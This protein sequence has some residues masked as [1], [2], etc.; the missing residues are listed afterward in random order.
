M[1]VWLCFSRLD[2]CVP[3]VPAGLLVHCVS[4][5]A[6][7]TVFPELLSRPVEADAQHFSGQ[8]SIFLCAFLDPH[9]PEDQMAPFVF[10][11]SSYRISKFDIKIYTVDGVASYNGPFIPGLLS[12]YYLVSHRQN[13]LSARP[14]AA[15]HCNCLC[16]GLEKPRAGPSFLLVPSPFSLQ[17]FLDS[18]SGQSSS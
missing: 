9:H 1:S 18:P 15:P 5:Q 6:P 3:W 2:V 12:V 7:L 17:S 14:A 16:A 13:S 11:E 10:K 4:I 8:G